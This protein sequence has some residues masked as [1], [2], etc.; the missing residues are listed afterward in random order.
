MIESILGTVITLMSKE[1]KSLVTLLL[2]LRRMA[3]YGD[4]LLTWGF[5]RSFQLRVEAM[6]SQSGRRESKIHPDQYHLQSQVDIEILY[7]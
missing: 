6:E 4:A 3:W 5:M 2:L 1:S 7:A